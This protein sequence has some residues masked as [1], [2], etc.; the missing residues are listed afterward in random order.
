MR[1]AL[2]RL[3]LSTLSIL[4]HTSLLYGQA[5]HATPA[6]QWSVRPG[7]EAGVLSSSLRSRVEGDRRLIGRRGTVVYRFRVLSGM[8]VQIRL[9]AGGQGHVRVR[10]PAQGL[11][12]HRLSGRVQTHLLITRTPFDPPIQTLQVIIEAGRR[13]RVTLYGMSLRATPRDED[14]D[15][16]SDSTERLLGAPAHALKPALPLRS[17]T[18]PITRLTSELSQIPLPLAGEYQ[19]DPFSTIF[20]YSRMLA[21]Q[22]H[23]QDRHPTLLID[24]MREVLARDPREHQRLFFSVLAAT[25]MSP[26]LRPTC[27]EPTDSSAS[28]WQGDTLTPDYA[29]VLLSATRALDAIGVAGDATLDAGVEG[30]GML[31][32]DEWDPA[33]WSDKADM[34]ALALPLV[35]AGIPLQMRALSQVPERDY[36][37]NIRLLLWTPETTSPRSEREIEALAS[38]VRG[39]G[40]LLVVGDPSVQ[41]SGAMP[42]WQ[43][44]G[45]PT[46]LHWLAAKLGLKLTLSGS[47]DSPDL[48]PVWQEVARQG[49]ESGQDTLSRRWVEI[50]LSPYAGQTV[51]VRFSD[52]Q[53]NA[54]EG[55]RLSQARLEAEGRI[56]TAFYTGTIV[57]RLFLYAHSKSQLMRNGE[58]VAEGTAW[59]VYRFP[60]PSA[61]RIT[62]RVEVAQEWRVELSLQPPYS[63]RT[64]V[65]QRTDLPTITLRHDERLVAG[66]IEGSETLYLYQPPAPLATLS[67]GEPTDRTSHPRPVGILRSVGRGGIV[68]MGVS[69]R[70]FGNSP[71]GE[72]QVRQL[73]RFVAGRAGLRYRERA[74]FACRRGDWIV[75]Y[76]TYRTTILRGTF[77]DGLDPRLPILSDV[78]LE[79]RTPRLLLQVEERLKRPGMLHT[80]AQIVLQHATSGRLAYLLRGPE[81]VPGIA[82]VSIR[83]LEGQVQLLDTLGHPVPVTVER[84]GGTLFIRWN[85]SPDGHVLIVR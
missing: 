82:R 58:R 77:L 21:G 26:E 1:R 7:A 9:T 11:L 75:A 16:I 47:E 36:L 27:F 85:L 48:S 35:R 45:Y 46:A 17:V 68:W 56:L 53:P 37:R 15:G 24:P 74:R 25:L 39:G 66:F 76:G 8:D 70:A 18:K 64:L 30:I 59:F 19:P 2:R 29:A 34:L 3:L 72:T 79:P 42:S 10:T 50:D 28:L 62:L 20:L 67:H 49:T 33:D 61:A 41:P 32:S 78:P 69:G 31:V 55:A 44:A 80:N 83:T 23:R 4:F 5:A 43:E 51:Y 54:G 60:L 6:L 63:E 14:G 22:L 73:I 40:W 57:E 13:G 12:Q 52:S 71:N 38:W 65:R 81:G 84:T